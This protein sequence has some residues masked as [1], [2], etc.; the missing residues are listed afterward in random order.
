MNIEQLE[1]QLLQLPQDERARLAH[2]LLLSL[3]APSDEE[4]AAEWLEEAKYRAE[5]LDNGTVNPVPAEEVQRKARR[6]LR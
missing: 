3:D 6:L 1:Q 2:K 4:I 5:E